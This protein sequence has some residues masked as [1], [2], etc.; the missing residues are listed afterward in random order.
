MQSKNWNW[1]SALTFWKNN[2]ELVH[3]YQEDKNKDGL[4]DDDI[5]N[6]FFIGKSL[7]AI[8]GYDQNGIVQTDDAAYITMTGAA[9][10]APK[11]IDLNG[12]KKIDASDRNILGYTKEKYRIGLSN[13]VRYKNFE[14]YVMVSGIFGGNDSYLRSNTSAYMTSGT[15]RFNDNTISKPFWTPENKSNKYPSAYFSGDSRFLGLM[16]RDFIRL[17]DLTLAYSLNTKW[18]EP[19]Q[20]KG[21]RFFIGAKNLLTS[22]DWI[23]GDPETGTTVQAN[24]FP[25]A[26]TYSIGAN[27]SF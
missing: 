12:D 11:Y 15:G 19:I 13:I 4:E 21:I 10:G 1:T 20:I 17:Q 9:P 7:G 23:G 18:M 26:T 25:V 14:L 22:T 24:T 16:S 6:N 3:L 5:A 2:N 27:V 8:Y